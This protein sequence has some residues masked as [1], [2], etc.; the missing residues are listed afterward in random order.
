MRQIIQ[1]TSTRWRAN[2]LTPPRPWMRWPRNCK[3][4]VAPRPPR[5]TSRNSGKQSWL[6]KFGRLK[7][8]PR[9]RTPTMKRALRLKQSLNFTRVFPRLEM[10]PSKP[11]SRN[12]PRCVGCSRR[13]QEA[14][15]FGRSNSRRKPGRRTQRRTR[16]TRSRRR[17]TFRTTRRINRRAA[18]PRAAW[19][20]KPKPKT[21][22]KTNTR[23]MSPMRRLG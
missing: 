20:P 4:C 15:A 14:P 18:I 13:R 3:P 12:S 10:R 17:R 21:K 8:R 23:P 1:K 2:A 11:W 16:W 22:T 9:K 5:N 7:S 6:T 19:K